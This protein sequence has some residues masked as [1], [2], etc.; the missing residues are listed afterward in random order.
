MIKY[1]ITE[2]K[3]N[4]DEAVVDTYGISAMCGESTLKSVS[5]IS[6]DMSFVV[7]LVQKLNFF[8]VELCHF[9]DV[10]IDELNR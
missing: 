5:D 1:I 8:E 6:T 10:I 7:E 3:L 4:I 9:Y 2:D